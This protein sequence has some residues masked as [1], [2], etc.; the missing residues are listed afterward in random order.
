M[1]K[2]PQR[3]KLPILD[4][5]YLDGWVPNDCFVELLEVCKAPKLRVSSQSEAWSLKPWHRSLECDVWTATPQG[6]SSLKI[7]ILHSSGFWKRM[8]LKEREW[9]LVLRELDTLESV[10]LTNIGCPE[11]LD[12]VL[13]WPKNWTSIE[14][15]QSRDP[16]VEGLLQKLPH[17]K[18]LK[19]TSSNLVPRDFSR[20]SLDSL[21]LETLDL[22]DN[23]SLNSLVDLKLPKGLQHVVMRGLTRVWPSLRNLSLKTLEM[24]VTEDNL[25]SVLSLIAQNST[26]ERLVLHLNW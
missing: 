20:V 12:L 5:L 24:N 11:F 26:L 19:W 4:V 6:L 8:T 25:K 9:A 17:L 10:T 23:D 1:P 7:L 13:P 18:S 15:H 3:W 16:C 21:G 2:E 14:L 22:S